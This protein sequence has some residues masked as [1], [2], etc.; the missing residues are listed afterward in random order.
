MTI[1]CLLGKKLLGQILASFW[2]HVSIVGHDLRW[3]QVKIVIYW[4]RWAT[5]LIYGANQDALRVKVCAI[6]N[7]ART[8]GI[9]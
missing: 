1:I 2:A 3:Y 7:D 5:L 8:T 9:M 4:Y 6:N